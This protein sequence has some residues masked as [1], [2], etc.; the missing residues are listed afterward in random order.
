MMSNAGP[1]VGV[2]VGE[3]VL[4]GNGMFE[5][6]TGSLTGVGDGVG[7]A[8]PG[9]LTGAMSVD[10]VLVGTRDAGVEVGVGSGPAVHAMPM[11]NTRDRPSHVSANPNRPVLRRR[12]GLL[13]AEDFVSPAMAGSCAKRLS[14]K[15]LTN[16]ERAS[17]QLPRPTHRAPTRDA[18]TSRCLRACPADV[19]RASA[20]QCLLDTL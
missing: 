6:G 18:P 19:A 10:G 12:A 5:A 3:G 9:D 14:N 17:R 11:A 2:G 13:A 20:S 15:S 8:G 16:F 4:V 7:V 1:G